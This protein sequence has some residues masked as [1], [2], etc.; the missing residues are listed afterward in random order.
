MPLPQWA[1]CSVVRMRPLRTVVALL[2]GLLGSRDADA[3]WVGYSAGVSGVHASVDE[4]LATWSPAQARHL[5]TWLTRVAALLPPGVTLSVGLHVV[6]TMCEGHGCSPASELDVDPRD[7]P[8]IFERLA[9]RY[10][11]SPEARDRAR[12]LDVEVLTLQ[13]FAGSIRGA[14]AAKQ[15]VLDLD[16]GFFGFYGTGAHPGTMHDAHVLVDG[17][18]YRVVAGAYLNRSDAESARVRLARVGVR[19]IVRRLPTLPTV[20]EARFSLDG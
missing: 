12:W 13:V 1:F 6:P 15:R 14:S 9:S 16:E 19:A 4:D 3:C 10:G 18:V 7:W 20:D 11:S 2:V 8:E 5:A 17:D